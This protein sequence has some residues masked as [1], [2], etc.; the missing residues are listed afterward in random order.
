MVIEYQ[1]IFYVASRSDKSLQYSE[2]LNENGVRDISTIQ[3]NM[4]KDIK[5]DLIIVLGGDG[6]MLRAMRY[7]MALKV[8]FYGIN[9]GN[10]GFLLNEH[11]NNYDFESLLERVQ[12]SFCAKS[13]ALKI[14]FENYTCEYEQRYVFNELSLSRRSNRVMKCNIHINNEKIFHPIISDGLI[15]ASSIG[16]SAYNFAVGGPIIPL[17]C[18]LLI[19]TPINSFKPRRKI[20][21]I[22]C[23]DASYI[24]IEVLEDESRPIRIACDGISVKPIYNKFSISYE[25]NIDIKILFDSEQYLISQ[26]INEQVH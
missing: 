5:I 13:H 6:L 22:L 25:K 8:P 9:C 2:F 1:N 23:P 26:I 4:I 20:D 7:Y 12:N 15:V 18:P 21:S 16:S 24:N 3:Q 17:F 19:L 14:L 11:P 10:F